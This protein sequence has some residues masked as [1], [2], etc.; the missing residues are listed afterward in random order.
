MTRSLFGWCRLFRRAP[1]A[2]PPATPA[3]AADRYGFPEAIRWH[4]PPGVGRAPSWI[5]RPERDALRR[6]LR[7]NPYEDR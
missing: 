1:P 7:S 3:L 5:D 2:T 6:D 4:P